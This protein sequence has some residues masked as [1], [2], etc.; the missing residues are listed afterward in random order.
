MLQFKYFDKAKSKMLMKDL[1]FKLRSLS[2]LSCV[3][4]LEYINMGMVIEKAP[5]LKYT[6]YSNTQLY[7]DD[8]NWL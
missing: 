1:Q 3:L 2:S 8:L 4:V 7:F 6:Y 5:V